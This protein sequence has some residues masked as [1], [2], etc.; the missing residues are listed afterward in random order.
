MAYWCGTD[1]A[2]SRRNGIWNASPVT[3]MVAVISGNSV[4]NFNAEF[5]FKDSLIYCVFHFIAK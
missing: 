4:V 3:F 5:F 1:E 2:V